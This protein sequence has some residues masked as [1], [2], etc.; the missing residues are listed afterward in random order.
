MRLVEPTG[1]E[2]IVLV[3]A[4]DVGFTVRVAGDTVLKAGETI[5]LDLRRERIH[6]FDRESGR[7]L[8]ADLAAATADPVRSRA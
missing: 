4:G 6:V 2:S 5:P 7:R 1:H 8:N 3:N